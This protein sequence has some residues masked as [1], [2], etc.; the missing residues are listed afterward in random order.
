MSKKQLA[1][2]SA[3]QFYGSPLDSA[4][5]RRFVIL[6]GLVDEFQCKSPKSTQ[7]ARTENGM[8]SNELVLSIDSA[9]Y[10]AIQQTQDARLPGGQFLHRTG[11][12]PQWKYY[13]R[14]D[15]NWTPA[16]ETIYRY[17]RKIIQVGHMLLPFTV[18]NLSVELLSLIGHKCFRTQV[19]FPTGNSISVHS[20][21]KLHN[22][23]AS[24]YE[25]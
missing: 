11:L 24:Y 14:F 23:I 19:D 5:T 21:T 12:R 6:Y 3:N 7:A 1:G 20:R 2:Q 15:R 10:F 18:N 16:P 17:G 8:S 9:L 13:A 25:R 22:S 4:A